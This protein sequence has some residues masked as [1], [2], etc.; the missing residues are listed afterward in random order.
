MSFQTAGS[1]SDHSHPPFNQAHHHR[2]GDSGKPG[3]PTDPATAP[4]AATEKSVGAGLRPR[5]HRPSVPTLLRRRTDPLGSRH[6]LKRHAQTPSPFRTGSSDT[7][8]TGTSAIFQNPSVNIRPAGVMHVD[9][10]KHPVDDGQRLHPADA[11]AGAGAARGCRGLESAGDVRRE[12]AV[13]ADRR[14]NQSK[15]HHRSL[16]QRSGRGT[17]Q[18]SPRCTLRVP[19]DDPRD[20]GCGFRATWVEHSRVARPAASSPGIFTGS[21]EG[22]V[23]TEL[24]PTRSVDLCGGEDDDVVVVA[25]VAGVEV[26]AAADDHQPGGAGLGEQV[27]W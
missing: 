1:S 26:A 25:S 3:P 22:T 18:S 24:G 27:G 21:R 10:Q 12:S 9:G 2:K 11:G 19:L 13:H 20:R 23:I 8:P 4:T 7:G 14:R 15:P 17:G 5:R 6:C 16:G